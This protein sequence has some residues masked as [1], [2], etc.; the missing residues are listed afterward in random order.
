MP[1]KKETGLISLTLITL[2]LAAMLV[3]SGFLLFQWLEGKP[4][5]L[6]AEGIAENLNGTT[7][8]MNMQESTVLPADS[9]AVNAVQNIYP[10]AN[11]AAQNAGFDLS[12]VGSRAWSDDEFYRLTQ[13][14][15]DHP[16]VIEPLALEY[17]ETTERYAQMRLALL[18]GQFDASIITDVGVELALS[19]DPESQRSGLRLLGKQ[20]ARVSLVPAI[21]LPI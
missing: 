11:L 4:K 9:S 1:L 14:L 21:Q 18:L 17:R 6:T 19:G 5:P 3:V 12:V 8:N 7:S 13:L 16:E 15:K 10:D 20:Q 2:V